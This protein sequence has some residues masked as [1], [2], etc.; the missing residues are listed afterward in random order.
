M[1]GAKAEQA[2]ATK[3]FGI[4]GVNLGQNRDFFVQN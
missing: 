4:L 1:G 3:T 2:W